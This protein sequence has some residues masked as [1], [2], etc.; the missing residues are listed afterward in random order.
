MNDATTAYRTMSDATVDA[1]FGALDQP[2]LALD[3]TRAAVREA[4]NAECAE[5]GQMSC[6]H[7]A[8]HLPE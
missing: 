6:E 4:W 7:P 3:D 8:D 1:L 5:C 2:T